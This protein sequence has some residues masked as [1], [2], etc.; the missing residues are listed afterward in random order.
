MELV[1]LLRLASAIS[2]TGLFLKVISYNIAFVPKFNSK[3]VFCLPTFIG[4]LEAILVALL[5]F[6]SYGG[7]G[8]TRISVARHQLREV[9]ASS[10][11]NS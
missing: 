6:L 11:W 2:K 1:I 5:Q 4:T 8:G 9:S 10:R 7:A 3:V